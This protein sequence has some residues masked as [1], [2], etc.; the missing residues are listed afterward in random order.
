M[1]NKEILI[2]KMSSLGDILQAINLV[3]YIKAKDPDIKLTWLVEQK[4]YSLLKTFPQIDH[5]F[6]F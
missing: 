5:I 6:I 4:H 2:V 3:N 1:K